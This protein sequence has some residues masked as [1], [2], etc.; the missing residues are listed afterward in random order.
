MQICV[1]LGDDAR[2]KLGV[3]IKARVAELNESYAEIAARADVHPSQVSRICRGEFRTAS[4]NL[5]QICRA[6]GVPIQGPSQPSATSRQQRQLEAAVVAVW[7]RSSGDANR[8][9]KLLKELQAFRRR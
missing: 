1:K 3:A 6:I 5:V 2:R 9:V 8:L 4:P 7:D